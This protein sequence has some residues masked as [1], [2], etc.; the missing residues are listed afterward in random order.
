MDCTYDVYMGIKIRVIRN[1]FIA[2]ELIIPL[3]GAIAEQKYL[4]TLIITFFITFFK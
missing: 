2:K 1:D 3:C 4:P